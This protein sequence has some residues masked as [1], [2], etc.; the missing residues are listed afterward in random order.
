MLLLRVFRFT[1][2]QSR[3]T[4]GNVSHPFS[5]EEH[6]LRTSRNSA[7]HWE[8]L[9]QRLS[10]SHDRRLRAGDAATGTADLRQAGH[11]LEVE[12][13]LLVIQ[14][15]HAHRRVQRAAR[16][17]VPLDDDLQH[18]RVGVAATRRP[19]DLT[20]GTLVGGSMMP[21]VTP[22]LPTEAAFLRA[23]R[24]ARAEQRGAPKQRIARSI[25]IV[26]TRKCRRRSARLP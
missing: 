20:P 3:A 5:S 19:S 24:L 9:R 18:G 13:H 2:I 1:T 14:R 23:A 4:S 21:L 22:T 11:V 26:M 25:I 6:I 10:L 7:A 12:A 15:Q 8:P 16:A 17:E